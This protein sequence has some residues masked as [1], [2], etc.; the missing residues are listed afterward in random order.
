MRAAREI[1]MRFHPV[2]GGITRGVANGG[3]AP[4]S[5]VESEE[6]V[7]A[8]MERVIKQYHDSSR[9]VQVDAKAAHLHR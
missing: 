7:L 8:D 1:G 2:R 3:S 6:Q 9:Q 5:L 4:Q